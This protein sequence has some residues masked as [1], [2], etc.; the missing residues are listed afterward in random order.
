MIKK[1]NALS[2]STFLKNADTCYNLSKVPKKNKY[3]KTSLIFGVFSNLAESN[4]NKI[5]VELSA[6]SKYG[7][8]ISDEYGS[9]SLCYFIQENNEEFTDFCDSINKITE[10]MCK[11][12]NPSPI[13]K[14][15]LT[16]GK[17]GQFLATRLQK[18]AR[19]YIEKNGLRSE[20]KKID[21]PIGKNGEYISK[22]EISYLDICIADPPNCDA[23]LMM[24]AQSLVYVHP[25]EFSSSSNNKIEPDKFADIDDDHFSEINFTFRS[26]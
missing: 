3:K 12:L 11:S 25:V 13:A 24:Y 21:F 16:E 23:K 5:I 14:S 15:C 6:Y 9:I 22:L 2:M 7:I 20:V 4:S 19:F 26:E 8:K 17:T 1:P 10:N 18:W